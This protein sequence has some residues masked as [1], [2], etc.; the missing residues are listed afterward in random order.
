MKAPIP[1]MGE[2]YIGSLR[3]TASEDPRSAFGDY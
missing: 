3:V 2:V 1:G